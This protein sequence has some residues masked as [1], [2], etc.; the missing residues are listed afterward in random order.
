[1][2]EHFEVERINYCKMAVD[3]QISLEEAYINI[4]RKSNL[5]AICD[6]EAWHYYHDQTKEIQF[7]IATHYMIEKGYDFNGENF[8]KKG[9]K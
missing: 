1:M 6:S 4:I 9:N 7:M 3:K 2:N 5:S 8:E